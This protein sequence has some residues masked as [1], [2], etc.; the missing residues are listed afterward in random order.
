MIKLKNQTLGSYYLNGS[1]GNVRVF[2]RRKGTLVECENG[3]N[4]YRAKKDGVIV[5]WYGMP[6]FDSGYHAHE[7]PLTPSGIK[8]AHKIAQSLADQRLF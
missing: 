5:Q 2:V 6:H 4:D 1:C 8:K 7:L 3:R